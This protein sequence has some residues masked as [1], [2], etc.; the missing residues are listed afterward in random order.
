MG[1]RHRNV[2]RSA[3]L[4]VRNLQRA[5]NF[6]T[7]ILNTEPE[8]G[9][10]EAVFRLEGSTLTLREV[11]EARRPP[12]G[13]SGLYHIA[14]TV[15]SL[16][17]LSEAFRRVYRER[18]PL[19]GLAD[20]GYTIAVYTID[21]EGNGVEIYWDKDDPVPRLHTK[22]LNP[23]TLLKVN[24]R[25]DYIASI[26]HIHLKVPSLEEAEEFYTGTLKMRVTERGYPGALFFAYGDYHHH[27]AANIWETG[28]G[29]KGRAP[30]R[31]SIGLESYTIKPPGTPGL[32]P[33]RYKDPAGVAV[34]VE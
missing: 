23:D 12:P 27:V 10:G 28:W 18:L 8:L 15:D 11:R 7:L 24:P 3:T 30:P 34:I 26:G 17:G 14:F 29:V 13:S 33:G 32:S 5:I 9:V 22:P 20:H 4:I 31:P 6:Y 2:I 16:E 21:P 19:L 25:R 1:F